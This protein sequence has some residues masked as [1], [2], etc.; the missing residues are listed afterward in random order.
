MAKKIT[1]EIINQML[2]LYEELGT[3]SAVAKKLG[4]SA[5]TVSKYI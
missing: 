3:Y 5:S 1:Q 4:V 2:D